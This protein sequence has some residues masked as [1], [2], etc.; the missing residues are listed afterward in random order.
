[1]KVVSPVLNINN[2]NCNALFILKGN[3]FKSLYAK[4]TR[5]QGYRSD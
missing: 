3:L 4:S 1:M 5:I 2:S